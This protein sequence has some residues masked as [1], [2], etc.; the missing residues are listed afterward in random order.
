LSERNLSAS[1]KARLLA[2]AKAEHADFSLFLTRFALERPLYRLSISSHKNAFLLK[3]ALLFDLWFDAP[4]R[5]TRDIDLLGL[6]IADIPDL[7]SAFEEICTTHADDGVKFDERT[8]QIDQ[9]RKEANY[10]GLRVKLTGR[11]DTAI[12]TVQIDVGYGDAVTP[13]AEMADYPTLLQEFPA[14]RLRVYPRYTVVA[15]KLE[16]IIAL[17]MINSRL[18]DYFDLWTVLRSSQLDQ[19]I[20]RQAIVATL[21]R[22][23]TALPSSLPLR[24]SDDFAEDLDKISQWNAFITRNKLNAPSLADTVAEIRNRVGFIFSTQKKAGTN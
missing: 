11:I 19:H 1:V 18:K 16:A 17:G 2:K 14:P 5:P 20:L 13:R 8:I 3:G 23:H 6:G 7:R 24:L 12:C 9:I 22:R 4:L 21:H 10:A 15:E